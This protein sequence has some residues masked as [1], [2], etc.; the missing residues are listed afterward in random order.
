MYLYNSSA[1]VNFEAEFKFWVCLP[2]WLKTALLFIHS[3]KE[4][5]WIHDFPKGI[6]TKWNIEPFKIWTRVDKFLQRHESIEI[7]GVYSGVR[8]SK[9]VS[10]MDFRMLCNKF[11]SH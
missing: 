6:S 7:F 11:C 8:V 4:N 5:R 2:H 3:W 1:I 9:I 10:H